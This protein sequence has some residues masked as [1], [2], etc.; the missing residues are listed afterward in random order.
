MEDFFDLINDNEEN[1]LLHIKMNKEEFVL[2]TRL[3]LKFI[4]DGYSKCH[5]PVINDENK[6][7]TRCHGNLYIEQ[8]GNIV[9]CTSCK[10]T[11]VEFESELDETEFCDFMEHIV[12]FGEQPFF[13]LLECQIED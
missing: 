4:I 1:D 5:K 2:K 11:G 6:D 7:C 8:G 9:D 3:M 13:E 12:I 10:G